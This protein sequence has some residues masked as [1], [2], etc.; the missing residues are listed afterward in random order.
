MGR[1]RGLDLKDGM[2]GDGFPFHSVSGGKRV[3]K[4]AGGSTFGIALAATSSDIY[5]LGSI[6]SE[7][8][9]FAYICVLKWTMG[10]CLLPILG[11][12]LLVQHYRNLFEH[13]Q[14]R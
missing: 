14:R 2:L 6:L 9:Y 4:A 11:Y 3:P 5:D 10:E 13:G 1:A 8:I 12:G 7:K